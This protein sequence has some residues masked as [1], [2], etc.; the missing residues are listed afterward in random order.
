MNQTIALTIDAYRELNA[1]KL[2]W[3]TLILSALVVAV[4]A[5]VGI[6]KDGFSVFGWSPDLFQNDINGFMTD[7][8]LAEARSVFYKEVF[9]F[10]GVTIWLTWAAII[11]ALI[12]TASIFPNMMTS[13]AIDTLLTKPISRLRL[14]ITKYFLGLGFVALQVTVFCVTSFFVIGLRAATWEPALFL[15][16]PIVLLFFSYLYAICVLV[17]VMT[18]STMLAVIVTILA[19]LGMFA[20]NFTDGKILEAQAAAVLDAEIAEKRL[21]HLETLPPRPLKELSASESELA[22]TGPVAGDAFPDDPR[23]NFGGGADDP[24][25]REGYAETWGDTESLKQQVK[26]ARETAEA[27]EKWRGY[28]FWVKTPLPKTGETRELMV[29][30][31]RDEDVY[32]DVVFDPAGDPEEFYDPMFG[33]RIQLAAVK[34]FELGKEQRGWAWIILTSIL[35]EFVVVGLAAWRFCRRD[36]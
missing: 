9:N 11:L 27:F 23:Q 16:I 17:G 29:R 1:K 15:A 4:I 34:K 14:F 33:D 2:F 36:Y 19:W 25:T 30:S 3:I 26:M 6:D 7:E 12:S 20:L 32:D 35:F 5:A 31:L 10:V 28:A 8:E 24:W 18:R 13:G 21:A 22:P